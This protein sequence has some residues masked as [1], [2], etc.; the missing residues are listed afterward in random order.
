MARFVA[1]SAPDSEDWLLALPVTSGG[2]TLSDKSIRV[3]VGMR[4]GI[5]LCEPHVCRYE[6]QVDARGLHGLTRKLTPSLIENSF[7]LA[8][9]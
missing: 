6:A 7:L 2:L 9:L 8:E 3:A 1:P 5:N 4:L